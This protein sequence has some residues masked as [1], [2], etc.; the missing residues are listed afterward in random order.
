MFRHFRDSKTLFKQ[1]LSTVALKFS[2]ESVLVTTHI[3]EILLTPQNRYCTRS[4]AE[5]I[6]EAHYIQ[7]V[8]D[9]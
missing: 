8:N 9:V 2:L 4:P 3:K 7:M 1:K 5:N 6:F